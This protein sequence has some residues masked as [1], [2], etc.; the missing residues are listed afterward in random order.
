MTYQEQ[1]A[2]LLAAGFKE[3][4]DKPQHSLWGDAFF[5]KKITDENGTRYYIDA[6]VWFQEN[7][8][9]GW[10]WELRYN[11]GCS[12]CR[13]QMTM[14]IKGHCHRSDWTAADILAWAEELWFRLSPN[15]YERER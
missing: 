3:F 1:R 4:K 5:Q 15:Y 11:D 7:G 6:L 13:P 9:I 10:E 8:R 2:D 12:F 14:Q